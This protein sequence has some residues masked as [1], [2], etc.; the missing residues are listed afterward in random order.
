VGIRETYITL[1][2][3]FI[4]PNIT[5]KQIRSLNASPGETTLRDILLFLRGSRVRAPKR[6]TTKSSKSASR[7]SRKKG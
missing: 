3:C 4:C 5:D 1:D 2:D 6:A 7:S